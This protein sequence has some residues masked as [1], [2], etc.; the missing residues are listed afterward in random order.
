MISHGGSVIPNPFANYSSH[1]NNS[2]FSIW[3]TW[4]IYLMPC[5]LLIDG[6]YGNLQDYVIHNKDIH[7]SVKQSK[8]WSYK[9]TCKMSHQINLW[10]FYRLEFFMI[11]E[12][13]LFP[14]IFGRSV[15]N[16]PVFISLFIFP[17]LWFVLLEWSK[18]NM[19]E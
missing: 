5:Y 10:T 19:L 13:P 1:D 11:I 9:V 12:T 8:V 6:K 18:M 14:E 7:T 2:K 17:Y 3:G 15:D 16:L 4:N